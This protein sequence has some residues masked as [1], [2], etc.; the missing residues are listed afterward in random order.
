[1]DDQPWLRTKGPAW[2]LGAGFVKLALNLAPYKR[3]RFD[4]GSHPFETLKRVD[5]PAT[6][7]DEPHVVRVPKRTDLFARA[8][9]G[10]MGKALQDGAPWQGAKPINAA[11]IK[12]ASYF[13]VSMRWACR[14]A[15][16]GRG[17]RT[18][19]PANRLHRPMIR[20]SR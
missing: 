7:I 13:L 9:I 19:S 17:I 5:T 11:K 18:T 3:R 20:R 4:D 12:A 10:D 1:M 6:H 2:R 8:Q 15:Q 14:A 16:T